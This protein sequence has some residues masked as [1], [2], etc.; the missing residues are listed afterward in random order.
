MVVG[1]LKCS[2]TVLVCA[3]SNNAVDKAAN[4]IWEAYPPMERAKKKFLR[5][6]TNSA[7]MQA[8]LTRK[9]INAPVKDDP[10]RPVYKEERSLEDDDLIVQTLAEAARMQNED[11][12]LLRRLANATDTFEKAMKAKVKIDA[13]KRS[14]VA[15]AITL[16]NR[17]GDLTQQDKYTAW[18]EFE[19]ELA[20]CRREKVDAAELQRMRQA[21]EIM[22]EAE[23]EA[24][25]LDPLDEAEIQARLRDGR[26][27]SKDQRDKSL[28]YRRCV[29]EYTEKE[30]KVTRQAKLKFINLRKAVVIRVM[31][32]TRCLFTSCNNSGSELVQLGFDPSFIAINETGQLTV[33]ALA[34]VLTSFKNW[35][36]A[37]LFGDPKQLPSY[38]ISGRAI[39][40]RGQG[41]TSV[42][43]VLDEEGYPVLRLVLQYQMAP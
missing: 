34:N 32:E 22:T 23:L 3:V 2:H 7:E 30:G 9:V 6:E 8:Y 39:E 37:Y 10:N 5:Y 28:E 25:G 4:S 40:F 13:K 18:A 17:V 15:A 29:D 27:P 38:P 11:N 19:S 26:I 42:L 21:G 12:L 1:A 20:A 41:E 14:N 24:L 31:R 43:T 33:A 16:V 36:A 35:L